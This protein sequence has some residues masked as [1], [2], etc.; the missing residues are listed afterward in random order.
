LSPRTIGG[1]IACVWLLLVAVFYFEPGLQHGLQEVSNVSPPGTP[2]AR[3]IL[4]DVAHLSAAAAVFAAAWGF[5]RSLVWLTLRSGRFTHGIEAPISRFTTVSALGLGILSLLALSLS[6]MDLLRPVALWTIVFIGVVVAMVHVLRQVLRRQL[7]RPSM[8]QGALEWAALGLI[9]AAG[10]FALV[11]ALA[12]EVE[13]DALWYHLPLPA[14]Y[15]EAGSLV[16]FPCQ[17]P[18]YY[19]MGTEL[20]FG[21]AIALGGPVVA[22]L[23]H[24]GFGGLLVLATLELGAQIA[25]RRVGMIAATILAVTPI[26]LWEATTAYIDL[27]TAFFVAL[28]LAWI[29]RYVT[30]GSQ[31]TA[32]ALSALLCGFA[33]TTKSLALLALVPLVVI[34]LAGNRRVTLLQ[35]VKASAAFSAIALLL[36]LPWYV[37]AEIAAG[38]PIFPTLYWLFGADR[39]LW[40]PRLDK[41]LG[42]FLDSFGYRNG[43]LEAPALPWD[44]T[45]H[46]A[47]FGGSIGP[48][49][50]MLVPLAFVPVV[51]G[52]WRPTRIHVLVA[53]FCLAYLLLWASPLS[54]LQL[55]FLI[56]IL[57]PLAVLASV[58]FEKA[59]S[60]AGGLSSRLPVVMAVLVLAIMSLSLPP[61]LRMHERDRSGS[62]GWLT[63][64]LREVP[65]D[66]V[67]GAENRDAYLARRLPIYAAIQRL[68]A[69]AGSDDR[70]I[71]IDRPY[72]LYSQAELV[73]FYAHCLRNAGQAQRGGEETA[74]HRL[75]RAGVGYVL[76]ERK[77]MYE[78]SNRAL[79]DSSFERHFLELIHKDSRTLLYRIVDS[80]PSQAKSSMEHR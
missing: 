9:G 80:K 3:A 8:P 62:E 61:F 48:V 7:H 29:L 77:K 25:S 41:S 16:D 4:V 73:P 10:A 38:N 17:Y 21:Y 71:V 54:S 24:C 67:T 6:L 59:C 20:L 64:V 58:G 42:T 35:R 74:Y 76:F 45:M 78:L 31:P 40:S 53:F 15:L 55:R 32:L 60:M 18:S 43:P 28:S 5:G 34:A 68:N 50:L 13:Y 27:S 2:S 26:I 37:R 23:I 14:A 52:L 79:T 49:F 65:L 44:V 1:L 47:A 30:T 46:G 36:P 56:P 12:P 72:N 70:A 11:G 33:L 75:R 63:H 51:F 22:K 69:E 19:P 57:S 39:T 66:V